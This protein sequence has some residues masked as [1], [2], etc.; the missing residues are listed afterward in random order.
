M[1]KLLLKTIS[2]ILLII[3]ACW[4]SP[5]TKS[6]MLFNNRTIENINTW[7]N[8]I[9]DE[10]DA[11]NLW[12]AEEHQPLGWITDMSINLYNNM[13]LYSIDYPKLNEEGEP[14]EPSE[15]AKGN[16][17]NGISTQVILLC[18][19]ER[20][21]VKE[22]KNFPYN[23]FN[24]RL[25]WLNEDVFLINGYEIYNIEGNLVNSIEFPTSAF[26]INNGEVDK[27]KQNWRF[28]NQ[29][30][31][32]KQF[33]SKIAYLQ[34][35]DYSQ[36]ELY[37]YDMKKQKF[38]PSIKLEAQNM[39]GASNGKLFWRDAETLDCA[40][41]VGADFD[42]AAVE[43]WRYSIKTNQIRKLK[44]L[45]LK[46]KTYEIAVLDFDQDALVLLINTDLYYYDPKDFSLKYLL[47][48][49]KKAYS[50]DQ[51]INVLYIK[52]PNSY[53][54]LKLNTHQ[55]YELLVSGSYIR[56]GLILSGRDVMIVTPLIK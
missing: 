39:E 31:D 51:E 15:D 25:T 5:S 2:S 9:L 7:P 37:V 18:G 16:I 35:K 54:F 1:D 4:N 53:T 28:V 41:K 12:H 49:N 47:P 50:Y 20:I 6:N 55:K 8:N 27:E 34:M 56:Q 21:V 45:D 40:I 46:A 48:L 22:W 33:D 17:I 10:T 24:T 26:S 52:T 13:L 23:H 43:I 11:V 3:I 19:Q 30:Q 14:I 42:H 44:S 29:C 38:F 36:L 32:I